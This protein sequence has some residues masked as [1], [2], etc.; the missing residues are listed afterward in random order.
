[1]VRPSA[2]ADRA[3]TAVAPAAA[4]AAALPGLAWRW[5]G[6]AMAA[7]AVVLS[8][9]SNGYG[10]ERDELYFRMLPPAWGYAD[11]GPFT[12]LMA[13]LAARLSGSPWAERV[14]AT[15]FAVLSLLVLV[16]ITREL[17]GGSAAQGLCAWGYAFAPVPLVFG[18]VLLTASADIVVWPLACLFTIRAVRRGQPRWWLAAG[19][20]T[21]LRTYN[22][23]LI[24][25]LVV[26]VVAGLLITGPRRALAG[27]W[28]VLAVAVAIA[29]A[30]PNLI[31]QAAHGWPELA[32]GRALRANNAAM[33]RVL[34]WP[35]LIILLGLPLAPVWFA[36]L[37]A[38][39]R[40]PQWRALRFLPAAF[41]VLLAE[42]FLA[43]G[44][45]YYPMGL[46]TV[47][48]AAGCVPAAGFLA[49]SRPRRLAAAGGIGV[50][51]AVAALIALPL[52]P[53]SV[54]G[55]T[56]IP[57]IDQAVRDQI[58]WP[59]YAAEV[60]AVYRSIPAAERARTVVI[61][62]NYGE[63]GGLARYGPALGLPAPYSGHNA[64]Y[65]LRR[66][67]DSAT[68]AVLVG[69]QLPDVRGDFGSCVIAGHLQDRSGVSNQEQG[70]PIAI[71]RD[72]RR[73]WHELWP[74]FRHLG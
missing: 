3:A 28:F 10:F 20:V 39:W 2:S 74:R 62:S 25:L 29:V 54:L 52:V 6:P 33:V 69:A 70:Q 30:V 59:Q 51:A 26:A 18:H 4:P 31:Y 67:P 40:R 57:A 47:I 68:T 24:A 53:V 37:A 56:P 43:G 15:A 34:M 55:R 49:Q 73:W 13:G 58:G 36:G 22:K 17:G 12:P 9:A 65:A 8:A 63:A 64:L 7:L 16:L 46:L 72:P 32:E 61:A 66:P 45:L 19:L 60:A 41:A 27:R 21:G 5:A 38:L 11:Q 23:L 50:N 1:M 48:Y 42:T 71:C 44:Q 14:P 35:Y